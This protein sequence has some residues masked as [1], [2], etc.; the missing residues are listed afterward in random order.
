MLSPKS[1]IYILCIYLL[2]QISEGFFTRPGQDSANVA[3]FVNSVII[4]GLQK[5]L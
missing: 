4:K 1:R 2:F 3:E 5:Y